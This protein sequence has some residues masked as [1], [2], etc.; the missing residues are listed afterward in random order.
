MPARRRSR[1][2]SAA[3][4]A[5]FEAALGDVE[6]FDRE[7]EAPARPPKASPP[8]PPPILS[9]PPPP[10]EPGAAA[11]AAARPPPR[12]RRGQKPP[13]ARDDLHGPPLEHAHP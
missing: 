7:S 3:D 1:E 9:T 12:P 2:P 8:V 4:R 6:R 11:G 10:L 13:Q 5:L